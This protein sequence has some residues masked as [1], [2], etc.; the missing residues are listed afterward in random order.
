[1]PR[2]NCEP[3]GPRSMAILEI[4]TCDACGHYRDELVI[5][6]LTLVSGRVVYRYICEDCLSYIK[7]KKEDM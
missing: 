3:Y 6:K 7:N 5:A 1:M 4:K 2:G